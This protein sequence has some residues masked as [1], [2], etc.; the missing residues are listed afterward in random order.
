MSS[1]KI[2]IE[3]FKQ[4]STQAF[5]GS[6]LGGLAYF[7]IKKKF[8]ITSTGLF[9]LLSGVGAAAGA[10]IGL[11]ILN[12]KLANGTGMQSYYKP[13]HMPP[14]PPERRDKGKEE[15]KGP[16]SVEKPIASHDAGRSI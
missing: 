6:L 1:L 9:I 4:T 10:F 5:Y 12:R 15:K 7:I 11:I 8:G 2:I 3:I 14:R 16:P 13:P